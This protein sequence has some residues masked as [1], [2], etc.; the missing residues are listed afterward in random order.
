LIRDQLW[1]EEDVAATIGEGRRP[2]RGVGA[3]GNVIF[4]LQKASK[5]KR[6]TNS[7]EQGASGDRAAHGQPS[8]SGEANL[9]QNVPMSPA[10]A[11]SL[12]PSSP[13]S[14]A[15]RPPRNRKRLQ[16]FQVNGPGAD[17]DGVTVRNQVTA[18]NPLPA[19]PERSD[20]NASSVASK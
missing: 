1:L 11:T 15:T 12:S 14:R 17:T 18:Q 2:P 10:A 5:K 16:L 13:A 4:Q 3:T 19:L 9:P 20:T 7:K 6:T 8:M